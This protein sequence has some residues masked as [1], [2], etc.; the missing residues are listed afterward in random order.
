MGCS[1]SRILIIRRLSECVCGRLLICL[2][3]GVV[4]LRSWRA[5]Q[6]LRS[7][8]IRIHRRWRPASLVKPLGGGSW[9]RVIAVVPLR[10]RPSHLLGS[11]W[12]WS[13]IWASS[14]LLLEILRRGNVLT[15]RHRARPRVV[16]VRSIDGTTRW[17]RVPVPAT[18]WRRSRWWLA[19][20]IGRDRRHCVRSLL[21]LHHLGRNDRTSHGLRPAWRGRGAE[22]VG[23]S[24]ISLVVGGVAIL[25]RP[26]RRHTILMVI[27]HA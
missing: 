11:W 1:P 14:L 4:H 15:T 27:G 18:G 13:R 25:V 12:W 8:W 26:R 5:S 20:H 10:W 17:D 7:V 21:G 22:D 2:R 6:R 3:R 24:S 9:R 23:E 16:A 19:V